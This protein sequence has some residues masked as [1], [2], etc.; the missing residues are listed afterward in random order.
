ME[1]S[2]LHVAS[3]RAL[4]AGAIPLGLLLLLCAAC[5]PAQKSDAKPV[6]IYTSLDRSFSE[7]ILDEFT[8]RTG[9]KVLPVYDTESTK[10]VGLVNRLRAERN[11][12]RCDLFWNNEILNTLLLVN[13]GL[14]RPTHPT[15]A[16]QYPPGMRGRDGLWYGFA[17]RARILLVNTEVLGNE[18]LPD[19]MFDLLEPK[20]RGR[21]GVAKPV[22]GTTATH[23]ACLFQVLG[24]ERA[25]DYYRGLSAN[26]VRILDGNKLCAVSVAR[27][28]LVMAWTDTDD[29]IIE[30]E[31]GSPVVIVYP[32]SQSD[33]LGTLFLPNTLSVIAGSPNPHGADALLSYL[34]SATVEQLLAA[35]PSAQI[36]L[37]TEAIPSSRVRGPDQ[38]KAM[39][40]VFTQAAQKWESAQRFIRA[41]FLK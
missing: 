31:G 27:G 4:N 32:D 9:I 14:I 38:I 35:G 16:A 21:I 7:P 37:N 33:Q 36:P 24:N 25:K 39:P 30:V 22:A 17:A 2:C 8:R 5:R 23:V 11:R 19:S 41:E 20:W 18:S 15:H 1:R 26:D 28:D 3:S 34:L 6:V 13:E 29:A 12:P 40:V 10:T